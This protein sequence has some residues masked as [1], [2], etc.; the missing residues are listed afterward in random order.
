[1][2]SK[3]QE[4][5]KKLVIIDSAGIIPKRSFKYYIKVYSFKFM[6]KLYLTFSKGK[7]KNEKLEKF[8][9]KHGSDD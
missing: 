6:K 1:M 7:D 2:S 3:N 9:K 4:L 8:Y 5:E